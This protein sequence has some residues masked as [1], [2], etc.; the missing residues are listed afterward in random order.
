MIDFY[1]HVPV[2][3]TGSRDGQ[4]WGEVDY[5][6]STLSGKVD[7]NAVVVGSNRGT[8]LQAFNWAL[9]NELIA[10]VVM[11]QWMTGSM[12]GKPEGPRRNGRMPRLFTTRAV[13]AFSGGPGTADMCA[14]AKANQIPLWRWRGRKDGWWRDV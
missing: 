2:I 5:A 6:M 14:V 10:T 1:D 8:D 13:A 9:K 11:A 3:V 12:T 4:P 7:F